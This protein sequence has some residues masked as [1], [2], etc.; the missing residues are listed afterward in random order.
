MKEKISQAFDNVN[1]DYSPIVEQARR[2]LKY[3][4]LI[5]LDESFK[6]GH[7]PWEGPYSFAVT[8]YQPAKKSWLGKWIPKEYQ[9]FLLT[10]NGCFIHGFCLYGL[11]PSMQRKTPLMNR[12]VLECLSLQEANLSWIHG[13]NVDKNECF[14][15]GGRT[16]TYEE[17]VGYFIRNKTNIICARN[18]GEIIG[19]WNDFTTFLQDELE[20]VEAM[21][22]EKT[23]EDWWS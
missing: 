5:D 10:F 12:K 6:M 18:N 17:N 2:Y 15:F 7:Q 1:D 13:Y 22:R 20:V 14:H 16:Y 19:E 3:A 8:L 11:P 4:S 21:M 9:N 23:P